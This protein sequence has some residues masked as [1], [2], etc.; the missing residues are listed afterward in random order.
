MQS[1]NTVAM[2]FPMTRSWFV[3]ST[4]LFSTV[5]SA[6]NRAVNKTKSL[7]LWSLYSMDRQPSMYC[8]RSTQWY[9]A[10]AGG[11]GAGRAKGHV[12][13]C[14]RETLDGSWLLP[15]QANKTA[16]AKDA[17]NIHPVKSNSHFQASS[18]QSSLQHLTLLLGPPCL[19]PPQAFSGHSR[20]SGHSGCSCWVSPSP[21]FPPP[22]LSLYLWCPRDWSWA[23]PI[24]LSPLLPS[25]CVLQA[26]TSCPDYS[27]GF[28]P[29]PPFPPSKPECPWQRMPVHIAP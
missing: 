8:V 19:T 3:Y 14:E 28:S 27:L 15:Q 1:M 2:T 18:D 7:A 22:S 13:R 9:G 25:T 26:Y 4:H 17:D 21:A 10:E 20:P 11:E 24:V 12:S 29:L 5:L 16:R 6:K 23:L